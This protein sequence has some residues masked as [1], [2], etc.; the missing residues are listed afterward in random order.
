MM[1]TTGKTLER[2][3]LT[4]TMGSYVEATKDE[5]EAYFLYQKRRQAQTTRDVALRFL[6]VPK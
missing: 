6:L 3:P 1:S 5:A 2:L 4:K